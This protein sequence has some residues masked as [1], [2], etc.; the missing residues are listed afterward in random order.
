MRKFLAAGAVAATLALFA[1]ETA[2]ANGPW[3]C[4]GCCLRLFGGMHQHGPLY[5]YGPYYGYPPFEPYGPYNS[6][7]QYNPYYYAKP[8]A[9]HG[10]KQWNG[11]GGVRNLFAGHGKGNCGNGNC[12]GTPG[13]ATGNC[14]GTATPAAAPVAKPALTGQ[15][16][17]QYPAYLGMF[18]RQPAPVYGR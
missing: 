6:N 17:S 12:G 4:G 7:L 5:N 1:G 14:G 3:G 10:G 15:Q 9:G 18:Y 11:F 8:D 13:C 16:T 2:K